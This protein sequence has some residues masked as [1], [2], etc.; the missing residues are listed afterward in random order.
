MVRVCV[1]SLLCGDRIV[2]DLL[3]QGE[4]TVRDAPIPKAVHP[5]PAMKFQVGAVPGISVVRTP[6]LDTGPRVPSKDRHLPPAGRSELIRFIR[7]KAR[8]VAG[9]IES[10][11]RD[12]VVVGSDL[13]AAGGPVR[14]Y[15][16]EL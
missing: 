14:V 9:C 10:T 6:D 11:F 7:R 13:S 15:E 4:A 3:P 2:S 12:P 8:S 5:A 1:R 16:V